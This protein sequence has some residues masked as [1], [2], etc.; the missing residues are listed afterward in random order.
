MQARVRQCGA[1][2]VR[3]PRRTILLGA[4]AA[5]LV[6]C[7]GRR[8]AARAGAVAWPGGAGTLP[9]YVIAGGWHTELG[10]PAAAI[11]GPLAALARA[12]PGA[13]PGAET[14]VF[15][16]GQRD[17]YMAA[18]PGLGDLLGAVAPGPA[19]VLVIP[20]PGRPIAAPDHPTVHRLAVTP[21]GAA[22]LC[23]WLWES[24]ATID[25]R[26]RP[27]GPGPCG[28]CIFYAA[29]GTY[30]LAHT[31]NTWTAQGLRAAG[32]PVSPA[33]VIT[34]GQVL[35]QLPP[36]PAGGAANAYGSR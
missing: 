3:M 31:C 22:A 16:W 7:A 36:V 35:G 13:H 15:G 5:P 11:S 8:T 10:L 4:I 23:A 27:L 1:G 12:H 28:G 9:L 24:F 30:D 29:T 21:T 32:L 2:A 18:H 19:V 26:P 25:G 6:G 17:Y 20:L 33:G 34:A 14:L